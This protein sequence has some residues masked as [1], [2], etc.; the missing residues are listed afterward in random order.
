MKAFLS[1]TILPKQ[2]QLGALFACANIRTLQGPGQVISGR[3]FQ[4]SELLSSCQSLFVD[5]Q[6]T[7]YNPSISPGIS[8][9]D[10]RIH[11]LFSFNSFK[12]AEVDELRFLKVYQKSQSLRKALKVKDG[13]TD[14]YDL[15][16]QGCSS[17]IATERFWKCGFPAIHML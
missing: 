13:F 5:L 12:M 3:G 4:D 9:T 2:L 14:S 17:L 10:N 16:K 11:E 15:N 8:L 1:L 6:G 7:L